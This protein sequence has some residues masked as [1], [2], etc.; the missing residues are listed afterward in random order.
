L[1]VT[2]NLSPSPG[3]CIKSKLL[4]PG[5]LNVT[6][7]QNPV[8]IPQGLKVFV[9]IA[10]SKDVPPP[11]DGVE[12]ALE[13]AAHNRRMDGKSQRESPIS[14]FTFDGRLDT[15]KAGKPALVFDCIYN[16][17]LKHH[18]SKD[19]EFKNFLM[20]FAL[21]QIEAQNSISLSRTLGTPNI[22][23]KGVLE[24]RVVSIPATSF[25]PG[26]LFRPSPDKR[27][28]KKLIEEVTSSQATASKTDASNKLSSLGCLHPENA[29]TPHSNSAVEIPSWTWCQEGGEIRITIQVSKL[30]RATISSAALDLEP[31]RIT[32]LIPDLYSI[33]IDLEL[34]DASPGQMSSC[35]SAD[36]RGMENVLTLKRARELDV[37]RARAEWRVNERCLVIVA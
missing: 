11:L 30:T 18:A 32:L 10:W 12:K 15:D 23:S 13:Y 6:S 14:V 37:D 33:D 26:H 24:Q 19:A 16:S 8:P 1:N 5:A 17:S 31:R 35:I 27:P 4:Q 34:S 9:N 28:P 7:T 20:E 21:Q 22:S 36:P 2:I 25:P 3:F 29:V